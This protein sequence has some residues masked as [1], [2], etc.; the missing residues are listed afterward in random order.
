MIPDQGMEAGLSHMGGTTGS[1]IYCKKY[2]GKKTA[3]SS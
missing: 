3:R 2:F 1:I